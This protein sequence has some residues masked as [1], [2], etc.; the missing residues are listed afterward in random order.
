MCLKWQHCTE[1]FT[2]IFSPSISFCIV[3][4]KKVFL[5]SANNI[6]HTDM[7]TTLIDIVALLSCCHWADSCS[8]W[9]HCAKWLGSYHT[10]IG[11]F[12][13]HWEEVATHP[14]LCQWSQL[15]I[16]L[17]SHN[18]LIFPTW[19]KELST[20]TWCRML[21]YDNVSFFYINP[22]TYC[23]AV[24]T[25]CWFKIGCLNKLW[26]SVNMGHFELWKNQFFQPQQLPS[27]SGRLLST[28]FSSCKA[29]CPNAEEVSSCSFMI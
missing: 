4:F 21:T 3:V 15:F 29:A 5:I 13:M 11:L 19:Y 23:R 24:R 12:F 6:V 2:V 27:V 22:S 16:S 9:C 25:S 10:D 17:S 20:I 7:Y 1:N 28:F 26:T 14:S 8:K 18:V